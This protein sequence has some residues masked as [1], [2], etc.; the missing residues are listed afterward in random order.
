MRPEESVM[1]KKSTKH[2]KV[3]DLGRSRQGLSADA[4]KKIKGGL[5]SSSLSAVTQKVKRET[6]TGKGGLTLGPELQ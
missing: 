5:A 3:K 6:I 2:A 4:A 1:A